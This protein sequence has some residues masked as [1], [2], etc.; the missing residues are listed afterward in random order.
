MVLAILGGLT[1]TQKD[2][3]LSRL[4]C[5]PIC[6]TSFLGEFTTVRAD[7]TSIP[8]F[9]TISRPLPT[10]ATDRPTVGQEFIS[11]MLFLPK[12]MGE[13]LWL[14][15]TNMRFFRIFWSH[16]APAMSGNMVTIL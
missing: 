8:T 3:F 13:Y 12:N 4:A 6:G 10:I 1:T 7:S 15:S 9:M 11:L 2:S 14:I 5:C 16:R